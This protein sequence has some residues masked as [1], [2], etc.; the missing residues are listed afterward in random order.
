MFTLNLDSRVDRRKL[1][2][3][4]QVFTVFIYTRELDYTQILSTDFGSL[5]ITEITPVVVACYVI[6][7]L[8][9]IF[10]PER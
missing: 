5:T 6:S 2:F 8:Q 4:L 9:T 7:N 10:F 1:V 3:K